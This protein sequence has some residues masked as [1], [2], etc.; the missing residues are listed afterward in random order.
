MR[1]KNLINTFH[2]LFVFSLLF[3][4]IFPQSL[5]ELKSLNSELDILKSELM[6][7]VE[8]TESLSV[9]TED[10]TLEAEA[11]NAV[12]LT[13]PEIIDDK[14]DLYFGYNYFKKDIK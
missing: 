2:F 7:T 11:V 9:K 13:P 5:R 6:D 1:P 8:D 14:Y 3:S 10:E 4:F 12:N